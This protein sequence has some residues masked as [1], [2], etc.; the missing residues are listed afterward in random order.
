M[1]LSAHLTFEPLFIGAR[2]TPTRPKMTEGVSGFFS[3]TR[4][5]NCYQSFP[6]G[7]CPW[8]DSVVCV[9]RLG[10]VGVGFIFSKTVS[11]LGV[12]IELLVHLNHR[13]TAK[14][15]PIARLLEIEGSSSGSSS[16]DR[17]LRGR[18]R[19]RLARRWR[20]SCARPRVLLR[21]PRCHTSALRIQAWS[22]RSTWLLASR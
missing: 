21:H 13:R 16:K 8:K 3:P 15:L 18:S 5:H 14:L 9:N 6:H 7:I 22:R 20:S 12:W 19:L 10:S 2:G 1:R 4:F 11:T 17:G